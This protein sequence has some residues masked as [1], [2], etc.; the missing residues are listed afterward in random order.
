MIKLI[1]YLY[2]ILAI[3]V[4]YSCNEKR[5]YK[6]DANLVVAEFNLK[7]E[8]SNKYNKIMP[9][10]WNLELYE[11]VSINYMIKNYTGDTLFIPIKNIYN[12]YRSR[13]DVSLN[14]GPCKGD[15]VSLR[16]GKDTIPPSD[17]LM[18]AIRIFNLN[19]FFSSK[20]DSSLNVRKVLAKVRTIYIP[21]S[22]EVK[23]SKY[24]VPK[25][26]FNRDVS[27]T[28]LGSYGNKIIKLEYDGKKERYSV[29]P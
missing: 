1:K 26:V 11:S 17:S 12:N 27:K 24:S 8:Y 20:A 16:L 22:I 21:D 3:I 14:N 28:T 7:E 18:F 2:I 13:V 9:G 6:V 5:D 29:F 25:I 15:F 4:V 23:N 10:L 19:R